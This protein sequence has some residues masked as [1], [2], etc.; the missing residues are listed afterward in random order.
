ML[1][2]IKYNIKF[3]R[4]FPTDLLEIFIDNGIITGSSLVVKD[5]E[6]I[7]I[8][9]FCTT[10]LAIGLNDTRGYANLPDNDFAQYVFELLLTNEYAL[11]IPDNYRDSTFLSCYVHNK[12]QIYNLLLM[13][14]HNV[15]LEWDY[16]TEKLV[17]NA[18]D[19]LMQS[20]YNRV[21]FF[22][23]CRKE[24]RRRLKL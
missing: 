12:G 6:D 1:A 7:D 13:D 17:A 4:E 24:Y 16:A 18:S 21:R 15:F 14:E 20:K 2:N 22:E 10:Y 8:A 19:P 11:Y 5:Y 23:K 9:V 3:R